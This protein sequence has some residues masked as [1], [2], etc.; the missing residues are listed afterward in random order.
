MTAVSAPPRAAHPRPARSFPG[1][2]ARM[3]RLELRRS[4]WPWIIPVLVVLFYFN[5]Y[6]TAAGFAPIWGLR[7]SLIGNQLVPDLVPFAAGMAAWVG[8]REVRRNAADLVAATVRAGWARRGVTL[9]AAIFWVLAVFLCLVAVIYAITAF[10]A[11]S[12]GPPIWPVAVGAAELAAAC[13]IGFAAGAFIP[14]RFTMPLAAVGSFLLI[15]VAFRKGLDAT[16]GYGLLSPMTSVPH[17]DA[18]VFY[19]VP[20]LSIDQFMFLTGLAVA[21]A[22]LLGLTAEAARRAARVAAVAITVA[23]LAAA[24]TGVGLAGTAQLRAHG[25]VIAAL[26][27]AASEQPAPYKPACGQAAGIPVCVHPAFRGYLHDVTTAFA[28]VLAEVAGLPGAPASVHQIPTDATVPVPMTG[29]LATIGGSPAVFGLP[30][31]DPGVLGASGF[32]ASIRT[33]FLTTYIS[34]SGAYVVT[35][36]GPAQKAVEMALLKEAGVATP[37]HIPP[38]PPEIAAAAR[39]LESLSPAA[40]HTWLAAHVAML[41]AGQINLAQLP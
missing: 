10:R 22:G 6:R 33:V 1:S 34:G 24:G 19:R 40:L 32:I 15:I 30:M 38:P 28:P 41:R 39:R 4:P 29:S 26:H 2:I 13:S 8:S 17:V 31:P 27:D 35:M 11:T 9:A 20:D 12:G 16:S 25:V 7:A 14:S 18:G 3:L 37:P 5:T 21:G 23:G 36:G